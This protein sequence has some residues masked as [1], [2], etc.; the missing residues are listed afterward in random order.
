M[1]NPNRKIDRILA[2]P[3]FAL[4]VTAW[5]IG[6]HLAEDTLTD[7]IQDHL[8]DDV[9]VNYLEED[10]FILEPDTSS[11]LVNGWGDGYGGKLR[12]SLV[13]SGTGD[14]TGI[15]LTAD[16]ETPSFIKRLQN[17]HFL[18]KIVGLNWKSLVH[19]ENMPDVITGATY[20]SQAIMDGA[21][22][23][24]RLF[25]VEILTEEDLPDL[26]ARR[27]NWTS[28]HSL[29]LIV[30]GLSVFVTRTQI[31]Q[32]I[33]ARWILI[34]FNLIFLGFWT[35]NQ[36]SIVQFSRLTG[37]DFPHL[38]QH[39][40][41]YLLLGG[42]LIF[43]LGL[44]KNIYYDR[45]CPFGAAQECLGALSGTKRTIRDRNNQIRWMPRIL[46]LGLLVI[47]LIF[48][49]PSSINYEVFSAFFQLVGN[50]LQFGILILVLV[51]SLFFRR[52]WCNLLCPVKP[53][54]EYIQT[55]RNWLFKA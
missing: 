8:P 18:Q 33:K 25:A 6:N 20:T 46:A 54:F 21:Q 5:F 42:S 31:L 36:L 10:I 44:N 52:P 4:L 50:S 43:V 28:Q 26:A 51:T 53:V 34:L 2:I 13:F 37:G 40:F 19:G 35:G 15:Y 27:I 49:H 45:I 3:A 48:R 55:L 22:K 29:L 1:I 17:K 9:N 39:L 7:Q 16:Q 14:V 32:K 30:L 41:F 11:Y 24:A 23:A 12:S 47:G 38:D